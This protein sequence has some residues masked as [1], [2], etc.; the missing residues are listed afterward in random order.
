MYL[1]LELARGHDEG[2]EEPLVVVGSPV[3]GPRSSLRNLRV[4]GRTG[5][6]LCRVSEYRRQGLGYEI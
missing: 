4:C 1:E 5:G 6:V 2:E 3:L